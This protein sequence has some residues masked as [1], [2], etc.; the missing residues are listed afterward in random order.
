L[1]LVHMPEDA[2]TWN[3]TKLGKDLKHESHEKFENYFENEKHKLESTRDRLLNEYDEDYQRGGYSAQDHAQHT[4]D[5]LTDFD[6]KLQ[7]LESAKGHIGFISGHLNAD[8]S[9]NTEHN[10]NKPKNNAEDNF[11]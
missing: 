5:V 9:T 4:K 8:G 11:F 10:P 3:W 2:S 6:E 7:K 1:E